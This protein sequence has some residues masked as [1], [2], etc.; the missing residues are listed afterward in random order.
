[1]YSGYLEPPIFANV[2]NAELSFSFKFQGAT[3][4]HYVRLPLFLEAIASLEVTFSLS[5]SVTHVFAKL[6]YLAIFLSFQHL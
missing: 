1:M 6:F 5:Q 4:P 2:D 3:V